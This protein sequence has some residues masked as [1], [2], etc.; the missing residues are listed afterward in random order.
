M[1]S[2]FILGLDIGTS[3]IKACL[4]ERVQGRPVIRRV[5]KEPSAGLRKGTVADLG[6][7][8]PAVSRVFE[9]LKRSSRAAVRNVYVNVGTPQVKVQ[10]SKG[11][12]AVSRVDNE[13]Y[14]DDVERVI[15][16]SQ[17]V[18]LSPNRMVI[19]AITREFI[20]D[21]VGDIGSPLGLSGSRLEVVSLVVDSFTPHMKSLM[22]LVEMSGGDIGG[23]VF[24]PLAGAR[25]AL[26][27]EQKELGSVFVDIGAGTTSMA[28]YEENKLLALQIFPVG[29][30]NVTNDIAV[31]L[32]IPV[33]AAEKIKLEYGYSL[34]RQVSSRETI[35]L[36][37]FLPGAKGSASRRFVA[38]IIE[39]RLAEILEFVNNELKLIQRAGSLAGGAVF[40]GGTAKM[41]GL[42]ELGKQELRLSSHIAAPDLSEMAG[43]SNASISESLEDPEFANTLGLV[44]GG[45]DQ[46][47]W[48]QSG[49]SRRPM[50][51]DLKKFIRNFL[52]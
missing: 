1:S 14:Q 50:K 26:S 28:V 45:G 38:E 34:A 33:A 7:A 2:R 27:K 4:M 23:L 21:G 49:E 6:E 39:S 46:E 36:D 30:A 16:A 11:I 5:L 9:D 47:G 44:L 17:A 31:G 29:G 41:P 20:V 43:E 25:S 13:I 48:W 8:V 18:S 32:K 52:P 22:R 12:V 42:A 3:S 35:D 40:A 10:S 24:N 37:K 51:L 19:H 15:K